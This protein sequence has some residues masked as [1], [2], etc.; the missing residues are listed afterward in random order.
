MIKILL[1]DD[2]KLVRTGIR[3]ILKE[4][5]DMTVVGEAADGDSALKLAGDTTPDVVLMDVK[6][7]GMGGIETT[8]R[9][10]RR[11]PDVKVIALTVLDDA[12]FPTCLREAGAVGYLTKGCP[13]EEMI[14]AI[15]SVVS[16]SPYVAVSIA[17]RYMLAGWRGVHAATTPFEELS[18]RELEVAMM[19][20]D[21][22]RTGEIS[23]RLSLSPKTI[24]TY[25]Q[26]IYGK[27]QVSTD[28]GLTRLALR[29]G[30][31]EEDA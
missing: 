24:S 8:R 22:Q 27:L 13:A 23:N 6:M 3:H 12:P 2:H 16:G 31:I 7:P 11:L 15:R 17:R 25:R 18:P 1:V 29:H 30:L 20:L 4:V 28:V 26:R 19:V 14:E 10:V 5:G 21:G 9:M